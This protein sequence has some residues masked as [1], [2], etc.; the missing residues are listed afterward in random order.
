MVAPYLLLNYQAAR[1]WGIEPAALGLSGDPWA[2]PLP[3]RYLSGGQYAKG[4]GPIELVGPERQVG[5]ASVARGTMMPAVLLELL[6]MTHRGDAAAL[7]S[8]SGRA[9]LA[10]GVAEG[11]LTWLRDQGQLPPR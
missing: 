4:V 3:L 9:A 6:F 11:I 10:R 8:E 7:C 2:G 5:P 1:G